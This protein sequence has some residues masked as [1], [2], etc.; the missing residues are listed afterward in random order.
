MSYRYYDDLSG[1]SSH[2]GDESESDEDGC[3][4]LGV[5][6]TC[7]TTQQKDHSY[8]G[9]VGLLDD[10]D[11]FGQ[12]N[13]TTDV[14]RCIVHADVDCFYCQCETL[15]RNLDPARP[16]AIGQKHIVVTCNYAARAASVTKLMLRDEAHRRCPHLLLVEGSDLERYRIHGR[17]IYESFRQTC[18][19][20]RPNC[21]VAKGSMDEMV[22]DLTCVTSSCTETSQTGNACDLD[23]PH[24]SAY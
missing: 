3:A 11:E 8:G 15:D 10:A 9:R 24:P 19:R 23:G 5:T 17:R 6:P 22:A 16:L 2:G 1:D 7:R 21:S 4:A 18:Q 13:H 12:P 14:P 20:L